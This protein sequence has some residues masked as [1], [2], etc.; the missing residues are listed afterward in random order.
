MPAQLM[1]FDAE[2]L[3]ED[4]L[5]ALLAAHHVNL[6]PKEVSILQRE[7][8]MIGRVTFLVTVSA[9]DVRP[10]IRRSDRMINPHLE[11]T[12]IRSERR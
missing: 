4:E 7:I 1:L 5:A 8:R 11:K 10:K 12:F 9:H 2:R 6:T 3:N